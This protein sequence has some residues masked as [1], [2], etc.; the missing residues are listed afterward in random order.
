MATRTGRVFNA[1]GL[2]LALTV[3]AN[4]GEEIPAA[5]CGKSVA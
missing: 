4:V 5:L 3:C 2:L 1:F